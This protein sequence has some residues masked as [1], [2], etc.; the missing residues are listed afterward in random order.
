MKKN[1]CLIAIASVAV[2]LGA[3]AAFAEEAG[4]ASD[5]LTP[6][7]IALTMG[8]AALGGTLSQG[9]AVSSAL[10][11]IGRNPSSGGEVFLPLIL[12]MAFIESL[13]IL[14][15]VIAFSML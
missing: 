3:D 12:G 15:F 10:E 13:V 7:G 6:I 11:A 2:L 1:I 5:Y 9:K 8:V 4:N 14:S